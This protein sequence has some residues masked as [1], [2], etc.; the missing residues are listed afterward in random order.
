MEGNHF[1]E[2]NECLDCCG[3]TEWRLGQGRAEQTSTEPLS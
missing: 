1:K 3:G 2:R